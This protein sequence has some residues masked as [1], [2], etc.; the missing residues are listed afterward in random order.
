MGWVLDISCQR[1]IQNNSFAML[2]LYMEV[3]SL[4]GS[5]DRKHNMFDFDI[6]QQS[7]IFIL[8]NGLF[9]TTR[10]YFYPI[11]TD[12]ETDNILYE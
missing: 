4:N 8:Q 5:L 12:W 6:V 3:A 7:L 11:L 10:I 2:K 1:K 9:N